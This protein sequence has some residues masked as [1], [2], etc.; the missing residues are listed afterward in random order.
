MLEQEWNTE[1]RK[2]LDAQ[3]EIFAEE[4]REKA[5]QK[6]TERQTDEERNGTARQVGQTALRKEEAAPGKRRRGE[7]VKGRKY[8][9]RTQEGKVGRNTARKKDT[10]SKAAREEKG[11]V[12]RVATRVIFL[13]APHA[14]RASRG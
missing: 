2:Q 4:E 1:S 14:R 9:K 7:M 13:A 11:Q 5:M 10:Q 12:H 6:E 3:T 8:W